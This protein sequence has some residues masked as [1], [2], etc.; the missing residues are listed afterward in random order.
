MVDRNG[1]RH[2]SVTRCRDPR[3]CRRLRV[4]SAG[5]GLAE[6]VAPVRAELDADP[7]AQAARGLGD[8]VLIGAVGHPTII[9]S[10]RKVRT[11]RDF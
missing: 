9:S 5:G 4:A 11:C 10:A 3:A 6:V 2:T 1:D 7:R 8:P